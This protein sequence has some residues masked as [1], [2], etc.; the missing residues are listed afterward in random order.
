MALAL[1]LA[2]IIIVFGMES[3]LRTI[4]LTAGKDGVNIEAGDDDKQ[5]TKP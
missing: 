1:L 2:L 4:K 5:E 3:S